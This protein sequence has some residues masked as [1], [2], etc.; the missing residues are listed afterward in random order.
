MQY[1][2]IINLLDNILNRPHKFWKKLVEKNGQPW[3]GI[4]ETGNCIKFKTAMLKSS[5]CDYR[6]AY[7]LVK[8]I[9]T[10]NNNNWSRRWC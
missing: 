8:R 7:T 3:K 5:I 9:I 10:N 2:K 6:N 4:Y 1:Q